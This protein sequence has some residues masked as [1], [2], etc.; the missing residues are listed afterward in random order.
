M[1]TVFG[2]QHEMFR[3]T[4]RRFVE[5]H[6]VPH[7]AQWERDRLVPREVWRA[8]G[9]AGLL[10]PAFPE[11]YGG[12]GGDFG[13][14]AVV[15][16]E[17]GRA[18]A[19]G[20]AF[21]L[22]SDI[23]APYILAYA[24]EQQKHRWLSRMA[25][26]EMIGAIAMTEPGAGSDLKSVRTVARRERDE[27]VISGSKTFIS[28]GCNCGLVIVVAKTDPAAGAKGVSLI[29]VEDGT[30]GFSRGRNLEKIGKHAQDT[31]ELF[32]DE[33]R[34]PI[35]NRL[36][37][38]NQGFA[39]LMRQLPQERLVIALAAAISMEV[40]LEETIAY[41]REREVFGQKLFAMQ[42][43]RFT[44]AAA[45]AETEMFR[46]FADDCLALHLRGA[47]TAE[48]AAMAKLTGTELQGRV[49]DALLQLHGGYGYMSEYTIGRA[50]AEARVGRI[51]GGS[52]EVMKE[53][54]ARS[55]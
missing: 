11:E 34:V 22:H 25:S 30:P 13:H 49:L 9:A 47:L 45:K 40:N 17:L 43:T 8:A 35:G 2:E 20:V 4:V 5:K 23:V 36:G 26:G 29:V 39:Y 54:I 3:A 44:L 42:N 38:E 51:Y 31:A 33:V 10:L 41:T 27:Y 46:V 32:F 48:R 16:E 55:L 21:P 7:Y 28:N 18:H 19:A 24:D 6:I 52:N 50:W 14:S 12:G 1:R 53:I 15:I 37:E